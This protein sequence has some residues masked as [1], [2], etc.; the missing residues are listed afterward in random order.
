MLYRSFD[1]LCMIPQY[2]RSM[3]LFSSFGC[4][5]SRGGRGRGKGTSPERYEYSAQPPASCFVPELLSD[6]V[7]S[8]TCA[9]TLPWRPLRKTQ[10]QTQKQKYSSPQPQGQPQPQ[11]HTHTEAEIYVDLIEKMQFVR[12]HDPSRRQPHVETPMSTLKAAKRMTRVPVLP[13]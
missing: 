10:T 5:S 9:P 6:R 7:G 3:F 1:T 13:R 12:S 2:V 4:V 8:P 11:P